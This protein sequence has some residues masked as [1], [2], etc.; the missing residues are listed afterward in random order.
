MASQNYM[1]RQKLLDKNNGGILLGHGAFGGRYNY[2]WIHDRLRGFDVYLQM[3]YSSYDQTVPQALIQ[4]SFNHIRRG[5]STMPGSDEFWR[6]QLSQ[7]MNTKILM[8]DGNVHQKTRGVASG[9]P[10]TS[11][12]G[13]YG[14]FIALEYA[15]MVEADHVRDETGMAI[16]WKIFT[17][18]DDSI[19]GIKFLVG[20]RWF[21]DEY[22][23]RY[24]KSV[25]PR[26]KAC[27]AVTFGLNVSEKKSFASKHLVSVTD[28]PGSGE[29]VMLLS[30]FIVDVAGHKMPT[31]PLGDLHRKLMHPERLNKDPG[32]E[33]TRA[34]AA[35]MIF[36][37]NEDAN[38]L[39]RM[40]I[41]WLEAKFPDAVKLLFAREP[42]HVA[43]QL[44][45]TI[46]VPPPLLYDALQLRTLSDGELLNMYLYGHTLYHN[47]VWAALG[48]TSVHTDFREGN[49]LS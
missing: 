7:L 47:P 46:D 1:K 5:F 18:G 40:Y 23:H 49:R 16:E 31:R 22:I 24:L 4:A 27:L 17:F 9:D 42:V 3:D 19:V 10:W 41:E 43:V 6:S 36:C 13:S 8:P 39:L 25:L 30:N 21:Y 14:N 28:N 33:I 20:P 29:S 38:Q 35:L 48:Y 44:L 34:K 26:M 11:I 15:M 32:W 12:V 2:Q 37:F 45:R